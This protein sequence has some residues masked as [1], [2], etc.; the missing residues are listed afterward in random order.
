MGKKRITKKKLKED[1][2]VTA[3]FEASHFIQEHLTKLI[4]GVVGLFTLIGIVW[5]FVGYRQSRQ[6]DAALAMF[7]AE[8]LYMG[9]QYALAATDFDKAADEYSGTVP[10]KKAAFFAG[11]S[12]YKAGQYEKAQGRFE[13]CRKKLSSKDP[14]M[15][16]CLVGL[17]AAYEQLN[18]LEKAAENYKAALER[19]DFNYQKIEIM[20]CLARVYKLQGNNDLA[21]ATFDRIIKDFPDDPRIGSILQRRAELKAKTEAGKS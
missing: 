11:D 17:G 18:D 3:T 9:G 4:L 7:K 2:F 16:N 15:V 13:D 10:G 12:Y 14:L 20:N 8:G 1:V 5:L 19:A 6:Q 21:L